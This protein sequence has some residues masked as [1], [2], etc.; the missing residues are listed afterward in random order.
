[1]IRIT[2]TLTEPARWMLTPG[3]R[4]VGLVRVCIQTESGSH[5]GAPI[6]ATY[7]YGRAPS[8]HIAGKAMAA[9]MPRGTQVR[10]EALGLR[11]EGAELH[12]VGVS[13]L[14]LTNPPRPRHEPA[15]RDDSPED[16]TP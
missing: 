15:E 16:V 13:S 2:G 3:R 9:S 10:V 6:V 7:S 1:M 14:I 11:I 8:A 5:I 12:A 4:P